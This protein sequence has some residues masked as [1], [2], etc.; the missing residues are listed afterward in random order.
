MHGLLRL[1]LKIPTTTWLLSATL[2]SHWPTTARGSSTEEASKRRKNE[3]LDAAV[4]AG[5]GTTKTPDSTDAL[6]DGG[7]LRGRR[8]L[9]PG[10][11][12]EATP[13]SIALKEEA[14]ELQLSLSPSWSSTSVNSLPP[15]EPITENLSISRRKLARKKRRRKRKKKRRRKKPKFQ[16]TSVAPVESPEV[17]SNNAAPI[18]SP[19]I[20]SLTAPP[21]TTEEGFAGSLVSL[22]IGTGIS[23]LESL[24][25]TGTA[26]NKALDW[27]LEDMLSYNPFYISDYL[28]TQRYVAAVFAYSVTSGLDETWLN[29]ATNECDWTGMSCATATAAGVVVREVSLVNMSLSGSIPEETGCLSALTSLSLD[30][31]SL[32]GTIPASTSRLT[33][34][35][36]FSVSNNLLTGPLP[37]GWDSNSFRNIVELTI[38]NNQLNGSVPSAIF[39]LPKVTVLELLPNNF[40]NSKSF[41]STL[42][43]N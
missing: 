1:F 43:S 3:S 11:P 30:D 28:L 12:T 4:V 24:T 19:G 27:I 17:Q 5:F 2:L 38:G 31:N 22:L 41:P 26:Q 36:H 34:L 29:H 10:Y 23:T 6:A 15:K 9:L 25:T 42:P 16:T 20:F 7:G 21:T 14:T 33:S 39:S 35:V 13:S 37:I 18:P 32:S 40:T 8:T